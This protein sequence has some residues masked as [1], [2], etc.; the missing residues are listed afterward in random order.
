[1]QIQ[2]GSCVGGTYCNVNNIPQGALCSVTS[3]VR[4]PGG[5]DGFICFCP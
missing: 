1:M 3:I 4:Y 5:Y 2:G